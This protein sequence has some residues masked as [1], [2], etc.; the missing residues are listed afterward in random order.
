MRHKGPDGKWYLGPF[1]T[2]ADAEVA[3][4]RQALVDVP[5][6]VLAAVSHGNALLKVA[7]GHYTIRVDGGPGR[8]QHVEFSSGGQFK[9]DP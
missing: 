6:K 5:A 4:V 8:K 2:E 7:P 3:E 1:E 9:P